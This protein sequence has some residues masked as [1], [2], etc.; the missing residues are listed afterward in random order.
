MGIGGGIV[1]FETGGFETCSAAAEAD[2]ET[3]AVVEEFDGP[4]SDESSKPFTLS[5][6]L[7]GESSRRAFEGEGG[8]GVSP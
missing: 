5:N 4:T 2:L 3:A 7:T 8:D 6:G 1:G